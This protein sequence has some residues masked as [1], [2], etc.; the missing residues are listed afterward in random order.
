MTGQNLYEAFL[1]QLPGAGAVG[2]QERRYLV[3]ATQEVVIGREPSCQVVLDSGTYGKV[4]RQHAVVR[5]L[6]ELPNTYARWQVCDLKSANGTYV[7]GQ[8]LHG[9]RELQKGD[10][11][12]LGDNNGPEFIFECLDHQPIQPAPSVTP[13]INAAV[14]NFSPPPSSHRECNPRLI[15]WG[16]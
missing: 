11:I 8:R 13:N 9:C 12:T 14:G 15:P 1:R 7:N 10:R 6:Q 16:I 2:M 4:S 3:V 5:P